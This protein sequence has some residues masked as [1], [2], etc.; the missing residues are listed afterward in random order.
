MNAQ[1]IQHP[2]AQAPS[3]QA[4][5]TQSKP[6]AAPSTALPAHIAFPLAI[7][8][9][10]LGFVSFPGIGAW[11]LA[12]VALAPLIIALRGQSARRAGLIG[13]AAGSSMALLGY[14]FMFETI[15]VF[16]AT[17]VIASAAIMAAFCAWQGGRYA[18]L[19]FVHARA[20]ARG[21]P[22][23]IVFALAFAAT[24]YAFPVLFPWYLGAALYGTPLML[25][26]ADLGGPILVGLTIVTANLAIAEIVLAI[27]HRRRP[28]KLVLAAGAL[29]PLLSLLYGVQRI[30]A[31]DHAAAL[32]PAVKVGIVQ[33]NSGRESP[34]YA[35]NLHRMLTRDLRDRGAELVVWS[36]G[37]SGRVVTESDP[38]DLRAALTDGLGGP[39]IVG[40]LLGTPPERGEDRGHFF[41]AALMVDAAG[42]VKGQY[43]KHRLVPFGEYLPTGEWLRALLPNAGRLSPG[44]SLDALPLGDHRI[45][46]LICYEDTLPGFTNELVGASNPDLLVNLTNDAWF[47][48]AVPRIHLA[49]AQLRSVEHH[50][51]LVRATNTGGSALIDAA[52]RVVAQAAPSSTEALLVEARYL[53]ESTVYE[54]IGDAPWALAA[55][56]IGLMSLFARKRE[57]ATT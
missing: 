40:T 19:G 42:E 30:R 4:A 16:T 10:A 43:A 51:Y 46:A 39:T 45:G 49:L 50:R 47:G 12:F 7:T 18:L 31:V 33:P 37:A 56:G 6:S 8:T 52:G 55:I 11:P 13:W 26:T 24:E 20:T 34:S 14:R 57:L 22:A 54:R 32:A 48:E 28:S 35:V 3:F 38:N 27:L 29:A 1:I 5:T 17:G 44:K 53:R 21:W 36:E 15:R 23:P 41:N 2:L 9:G 25:Q